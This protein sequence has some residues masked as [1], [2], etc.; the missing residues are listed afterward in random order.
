MT[1][2]PTILT[3]AYIINILEAF[4]SSSRASFIRSFVYSFVHS[5]IHSLIK[6]MGLYRNRKKPKQQIDSLDCS[7]I[8]L[9]VIPYIYA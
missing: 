5:F 9:L 2:K 1:R 6:D 8:S 7:M 3:H 4:D